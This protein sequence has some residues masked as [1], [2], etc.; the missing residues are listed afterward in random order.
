MH[1]T[2]TRRNYAR[3]ELE[4]RDSITNNLGC[5]Y[6]G[7]I[8]I[9]DGLMDREV[10]NKLWFVR[11]IGACALVIRPDEQEESWIMSMR[12]KMEVIDYM[13]FQEDR[14]ISEETGDVKTKVQVLSKKFDCT[15]RSDDIT[16]I[17]VNAVCDKIKVMSDGKAFR[18]LYDK[19]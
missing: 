5:K 4:I 9:L 16:R 11:S 13:Q 6:K 12:L 10:K 2:T 14:S 18:I 8:V 7:K 15:Y 3:E 19:V 17:F 1:D